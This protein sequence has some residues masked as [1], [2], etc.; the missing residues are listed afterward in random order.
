[1][2]FIYASKIILDYVREHWGWALFAMIA[3]ALW[4]LVTL[5][6]LMAK[7]ISSS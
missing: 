7:L 6:G 3:T 2:P 4:F 1:M 5:S